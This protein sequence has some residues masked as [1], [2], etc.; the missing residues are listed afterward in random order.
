MTEKWEIKDKLKP[1]GLDGISNQQIDYHFE[2][3]YKGY[4]N[5]L[6]EIWEKLQSADRSK[7]NQNYSE[8]R[9]LKLE[10]T[11][12]YDGSL[13]HEL[14]FENLKAQKSSVPEDLKKAIER[15]FG[16]YEKWVEDFK[17][18]GTAFRG[19]A[20]LVF[21][22]NTGKL[23]NIGADVHNTNGI[24]NAIVVLALDVYEHAYY[25]DFGPKRAG[26]LDAFMKNVDWSSVSKRYSKAVKCYEVFK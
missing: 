21:D 4:V 18:T 11:F 1:S 2:T 16:S 5:K 17:A 14:Y 25:T 19:W 13:L 6:N 23:R 9:E 20:L 10:E 26:Y 15:D 8:F 3:H 7:A 24:W 22:L 12:N